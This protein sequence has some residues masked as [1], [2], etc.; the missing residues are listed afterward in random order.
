VEQVAILM[1]I[2]HQTHLHKHKLST[3][4]P[5][6]VYEHKLAALP[7]KTPLEVILVPDDQPGNLSIKLRLL[8]K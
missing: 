6:H 3:W 2:Y 1:V 7:V 5:K 4:C 8:Q